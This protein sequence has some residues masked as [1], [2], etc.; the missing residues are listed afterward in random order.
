MDMSITFFY[1][2][3]SY[4]LQH[5]K[6]RANYSRRVLHPF[7]VP[8]AW[9]L[10]LQFVRLV[11]STMRVNLPSKV[12]KRAF[13]EEGAFGRFNFLFLAIFAVGSSICEEFKFIQDA[14]SI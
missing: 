12:A 13:F 6:C 1:Y 4:Y 9:G 7:H 5:T 8:F 2:L 3:A 11:E 14:C 10:G